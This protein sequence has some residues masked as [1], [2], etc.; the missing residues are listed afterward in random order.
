MNIDPFRFYTLKNYTDLES[1]ND[2]IRFG[3]ESLNS[4]DLNRTS[5]PL[6]QEQIE[7]NTLVEQ[8]FL[9]NKGYDNTVEELLKS[10]FDFERK[11]KNNEIINDDDRLIIL[12]LNE[13]KQKFKK[14]INE[15]M[16]QIINMTKIL[17]RLGYKVRSE[18]THIA[19][20]DDK[21]TKWNFIRKKVNL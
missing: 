21:N 7:Y 19:V 13:K 18:F 8:T 4:R 20:Y 16:D 1:R 6:S 14:H 5:K 12:S 3:N 10:K 17:K 11:R 9:L 15:N 2:D